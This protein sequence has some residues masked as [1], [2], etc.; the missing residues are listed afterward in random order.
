MHGT[1]G[2]RHDVGDCCRLVGAVL[3]D[4]SMAHVQAAA[5]VF[6]SASLAKA[7]LEGL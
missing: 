2:S 1:R 6:D 4:A 7:N 5:A 3:Q